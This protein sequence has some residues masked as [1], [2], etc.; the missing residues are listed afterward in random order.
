[1]PLED[2]FERAR[3]ECEKEAREKGLKPLL[4][5]REESYRICEEIATEMREYN[6]ELRRKWRPPKN[7]PPIMYPCYV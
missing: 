7:M 2:G 3:K 6:A 5:S 4:I 1:M